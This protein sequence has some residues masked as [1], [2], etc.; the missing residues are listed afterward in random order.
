MILSARGTLRGDRFEEG[1]E[2]KQMSEGVHRRGTS[3]HGRRKGASW[4]TPSEAIAR[5]KASCIS[6]LGAD[7]LAARLALSAV[8]NVDR[9]ERVQLVEETV[10][11]SA[12][13][14][15]RIIVVTAAISDGLSGSSTRSIH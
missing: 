8:V 14:E 2:R 10:R 11:T 9:M 6:R 15:N 12:V 7:N 13:A 1:H 4:L 5:R 3:S